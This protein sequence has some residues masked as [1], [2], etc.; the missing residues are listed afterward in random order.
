MS[1]SFSSSSHSS[2]RNQQQ[3]QQQ[4]RAMPFQLFLEKMRQPLAA[5]LVSGIKHFINTF[6]LEEDKEEGEE[7]GGGGK[8]KSKQRDSAKD[9]EK[10]QR[11]LRAYEEKFR[12][13]S[14]WRNCSP[15]E[16][17]VG[18]FFIIHRHR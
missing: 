17:E 10:I 6:V 14:L 8:K 1:S 15:E 16:V 11:F 2:S 3:Q 5:E 9:S 13:H 4:Q 7:E 12:R 18:S